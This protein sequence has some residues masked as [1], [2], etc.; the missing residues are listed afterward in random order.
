MTRTPSVLLQSTHDSAANHSASNQPGTNQ[1]DTDSFQPHQVDIDC[2]LDYEVIEPSEMIVQMQAA[3]H[4]WQTLENES[5]SLIPG[6]LAVEYFR[7]ATGMNRLMRFSAEPGHLQLRYQLTATLTMPQRDLS[8]PEMEISDIP[9][10]CLHYLLPSRYCESELIGP[11]ARRTFGHLPRGA[12]RVE[13]M[14]DWIH[15]HI[16][17]EVGSSHFTMTARDVLMN[18]AG[19]CRDFA[20]LGVAFCRALNIPARFVFGYMEFDDPPPDFHAL[21][22]AYV[23]GQWMLFDATRMG[24]LEKLVRIGTGVDAKDVAFATIYGNVRMNY[25]KPL[26]QDHRPG[27]PVVFHEVDS[28]IGCPQGGP[29]RGEAGNGALEVEQP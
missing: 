14:C 10:E 12:A 17:Y 25:M 20:H 29:I 1:P 15:E 27:E 19:V 6:D 28:Y 13:A 3:E 8:L 7:D 23:G 5:L 16:A 18:R 4:P 9:S 21:F 11:M 22:E 24:K 2:T 26:V